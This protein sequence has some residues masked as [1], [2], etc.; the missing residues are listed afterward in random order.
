MLNSMNLEGE[1]R[2]LEN[3]KIEQLHNEIKYLKQVI[4]ETFD[5]LQCPKCGAYHHRHF[6]CPNCGYD[7]TKPEEE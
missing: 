1:I 3:E 2:E 4:Y 5:G 7:R 6:I